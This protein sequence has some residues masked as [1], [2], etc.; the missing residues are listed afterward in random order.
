MRL[1]LR[2]ISDCLNWLIA[3]QILIIFLPPVTC[4]FVNLFYSCDFMQLVVL[5]TKRRESPAVQLLGLCASTAGGS[6]STPGLG[7]GE[8]RSKPCSIGQKLIN[9][10]KAN[11][12]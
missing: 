9:Y 2:L 8:L 12:T 7:D 1:K 6:D 3:F 4:T 10:P 11:N 5:E